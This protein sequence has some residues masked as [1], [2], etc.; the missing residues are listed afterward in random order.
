MQVKFQYFWFS[1]NSL[2]LYLYNHNA[3][4]IGVRFVPNCLFP[5]AIPKFS[6]SLA[7]AFQR[8]LYILSPQLQS[9]IT[10]KV[11]DLQLRNFRSYILENVHPSPCMQNFN[12]VSLGPLRARRLQWGQ[13]L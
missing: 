8:L 1:K 6:I 7:A 5:R 13:A 9:L 12:A 11:Y 2:Q 4:S 10:H 3:V